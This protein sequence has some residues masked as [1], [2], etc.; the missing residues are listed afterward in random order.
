MPNYTYQCKDCG[1]VITDYWQYT[2]GAPSYLLR[3]HNKHN[4]GGCTNGTL[5]RVPTVPAVTFKGDG[6]YSVENKNNQD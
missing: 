5:R 3:P 1:R 6:F 4:G 2:I